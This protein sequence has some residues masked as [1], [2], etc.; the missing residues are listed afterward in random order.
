MELFIIPRPR[1]PRIIQHDPAHPYFK[2]R[3][4]PLNKLAD[5]VNITPLSVQLAYPL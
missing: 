2:P 1:N 3:G 5:V 4:V